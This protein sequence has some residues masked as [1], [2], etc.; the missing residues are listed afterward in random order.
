M[1]QRVNGIN[2][3]AVGYVLFVPFVLY[4][5]GFV[6]V[7]ASCNGSCKVRPLAC[8]DDGGMQVEELM[9][10]AARLLELNLAAAVG[11]KR[12]VPWR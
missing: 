10:T 4:G 12:C 6:Y 11:R 8:K 2:S 5:R 1:F 7:C 9:L 3:Q